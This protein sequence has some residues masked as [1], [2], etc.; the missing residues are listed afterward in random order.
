M[1]VVVIAAIALVVLGLVAFDWVRAGRLKKALAAGAPAPRGVG[2]RSSTSADL[3]V[4]Q[5]QATSTRNQSSGL[6]I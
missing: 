5:S 1:T 2:R 3:D 6:G 4:V